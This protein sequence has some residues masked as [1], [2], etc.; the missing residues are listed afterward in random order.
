TDA[1]DSSITELIRFLDDRKITQTL[2]EKGY[3]VKRTLVYHGIT[4][5]EDDPGGR[6]WKTSI[7]DKLKK[8]IDIFEF[9]LLKRDKY[10][11]ST[12]IITKKNGKVIGMRLVS[13][14]YYQQE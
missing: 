12:E 5:N 4:T 13:I 9:Q 14:F 3:D 8:I 2:E 1:A 10:N 7:E 11:N 6:F